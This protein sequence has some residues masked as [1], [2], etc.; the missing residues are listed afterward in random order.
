MIGE[1][2]NVWVVIEFSCFI[3]SFNYYRPKLIAGKKHWG[4]K[5]AKIKF[6][7]SSA[8]IQLPSSETGR[9]LRAKLCF[10]GFGKT[11]STCNGNFPLPE[12]FFFFKREEN[13]KDSF[14]KF[15]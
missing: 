6:D 1:I 7:E 4:M 13:V 2:I 5:R 14:N 10:S 15:L 8:W 3:V 11:G 12:F 9:T